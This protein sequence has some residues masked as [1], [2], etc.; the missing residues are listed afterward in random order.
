MF[1]FRLLSRETFNSSIRT[2][3]PPT[4]ASL[5]AAARPLKDFRNVLK[6]QRAARAAC[7]QAAAA[8]AALAQ[9][10]A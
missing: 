3:F 4:D 1:A 7:S 5:S 10:T 2:V 8:K 9:P 6:A